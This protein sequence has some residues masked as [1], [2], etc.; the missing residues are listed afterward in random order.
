M[1]GVRRF[2][3][4]LAHDIELIE[5]GLDGLLEEGLEKAHRLS[6]SYKSSL[7]S[8]LGGTDSSKDVSKDL[9]HAAP[10]SSGPYGAVYIPVDIAKKVTSGL[11]HMCSSVVVTGANTV[12]SKV[13]AKA[14]DVISVAEAVVSKSQNVLA[15]F[16]ITYDWLSGLV[17]TSSTSAISCREPNASDE[18]NVDQEQEGE[19]L[20]LEAYPSWPVPG[21]SS[22]GQ[23]C[24]SDQHCSHDNKMENEAG[25]SSKES[26]EGLE[27]HVLSPCP[28][29]TADISS[30]RMSPSTLRTED[31]VT[32][33]DST[34]WRVK[35][36]LISK[37][38]HGGGL[39]LEIS[40]WMW[41]HQPILNYHLS[42]DPGACRRLFEM[43][44]V[45]AAEHHFELMKFFSPDDFMTLIK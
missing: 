4:E 10:I 14:G 33:G 39:Q 36:P 21:M 35:S 5:E 37:I 38:P 42:S 31:G 30:L 40:P 27:H 15:K 20:D 44:M 23:E 28:T 32:R 41:R 13:Q 1:S 6:Q 24:N 45:D 11:L 3:A 9:H 25:K 7:P 29:K 16:G 43:G 18:M 22:A 34:Y 17:S 12:T 8:A 19:F 26:T 2:A